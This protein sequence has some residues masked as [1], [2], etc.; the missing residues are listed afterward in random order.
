MFDCASICGSEP[1]VHS[2]FTLW[3][4]IDVC[5]QIGVGSQSRIKGDPD[6]CSATVALYQLKV[7]AYDTI[8]LAD[9]VPGVVYVIYVI[10]E[11]RDSEY[12]LIIKILILIVYPVRIYL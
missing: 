4:L 2:H 12:C 1:Q 6:V 3:D 5:P 9:I 11:H 8:N 7:Y 10:R